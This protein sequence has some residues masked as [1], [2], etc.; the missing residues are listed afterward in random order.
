MGLTNF[1]NGLT[2]FGIPVLG[3]IG[4]LPF[5]GNWWFVN[6]VSGLDGNAGTSPSQAL[7]SLY[8]ALNKATANNNDVIIL[9][10]NGSSTGS[11]RLSTAAAQAINSAATAGTLLWNKAATHLVGVTGPTYTAQ[12][13]RIAPPTGTYTQATFGSGLFVNVTVQGCMFSN[14]SLFNGFSTGGT[15]QICWTDSGGR[16]AYQNMDFGGSAD[17]ASAG[18]TGSFSFSLGGAGAG[19]CAFYRCNFG[20]DTVTRTVANASLNLTGATPRNRFTECTFQ[21]YTSSALATHVVG[22]G[23]ACVDRETIF[24]R[25]MFMNAISSASTE[26]NAVANFTTGA[27]GGMLLF[28]DCTTIGATKWGTTNALANSYVDGGPPTG[29]STGLAVAPS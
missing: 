29:S 11:A 23:N 15:G 24:E 16:N 2:S 25:C 1:P 22:T 28:K 26:I 17:A 13:A 7:Q 9:I 6:P 27:P 10:G 19:E 21:M 20:T 14:V 3:G 5:T 8:Q 4:G 12:R 18:D